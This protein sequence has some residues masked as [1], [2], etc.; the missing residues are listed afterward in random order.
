MRITQTIRALSAI[1]ITIGLGLLAL[2]PAD[3][4]SEEVTVMR[5]TTQPLRGY[6]TA[7]RGERASRGARI[8]SEPGR[9]GASRRATLRNNGMVHSIRTL[10]PWCLAL[11]SHDFG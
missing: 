9:D 11:D 4:S 2:I 3:A 7:L 10:F 5:H 1:T 6:G 8:R